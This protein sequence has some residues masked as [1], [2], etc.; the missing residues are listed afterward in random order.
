MLYKQGEKSKEEEKG[1]SPDV[2][3]SGR[4]SIGVGSSEVI[5][6]GSETI[7]ADESSD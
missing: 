4:A 6:D 3:R 7:G 5:N 2:E 1:R